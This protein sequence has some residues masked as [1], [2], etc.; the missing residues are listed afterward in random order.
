VNFAKNKGG[1]SGVNSCGKTRPRDNGG[2]I[3]QNSQRYILCELFL[4]VRVNCRQD[5]SVGGQRYG[6]SDEAWNLGE[7]FRCNLDL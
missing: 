5:G 3:F 1:C 2:D 4:R 6:S 7:G